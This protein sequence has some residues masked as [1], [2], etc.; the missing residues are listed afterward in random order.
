VV[1]DGK[2][3]MKGEIMSFRKRLAIG[4][5]VT[6]ILVVVLGVT[7]L[8]QVDAPRQESAT[9]TT[10]GSNTSDRAAGNERGSKLRGS[11]EELVSDGTITAAQA[12][13]IAEHLAQAAGSG[14]GSKGRSD[15]GI[16][17][18]L[19]AETIGIEQSALVA[20][21]DDGQTIAEVAAANGTDEAA[22]IDALLA[23]YQVTLDELVADGSITAEVAA[24][25][26]AEAVDRITGMVN[27]E[28][29]FRS[30]S[31]QRSDSSADPADGDGA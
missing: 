11:L 4:A 6:A 23:A 5:A 30:G 15:V 16:D 2:R 3:I 12:D 25:R 18:A 31:G 27:G 24:E 21:L 9:T 20:A 22:V 29:E 7:V 19:A 14:H 8:S 13:A 10:D 26:A 17:M 1:A 28:I